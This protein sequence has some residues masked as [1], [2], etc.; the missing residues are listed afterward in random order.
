[1]SSLNS[2]NEFNRKLYFQNAT[3]ENVIR[4]FAALPDIPDENKRILYENI[5]APLF[6]EELEDEIFSVIR[7][8][9]N[10]KSKQNGDAFDSYIKDFLIRL[11]IELHSS[12]KNYHEEITNPTA[13][14]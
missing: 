9:Q 12:S 5:T 3:D 7:V 6:T 14:Q 10:F 2:I 1:M 8:L 4:K 13:N 11:L